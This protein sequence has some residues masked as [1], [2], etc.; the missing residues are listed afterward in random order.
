MLSAAV[1]NALEH[2]EFLVHYSSNTLN[3]S[4][5]SGLEALTIKSSIVDKVV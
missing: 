2:T 1:I 3:V 4:I 5:V